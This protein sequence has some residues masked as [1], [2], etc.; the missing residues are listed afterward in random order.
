MIK[1]ALV[2]LLCLGVLIMTLLTCTAMPPIPVRACLVGGESPQAGLGAYGYLVFT[3]KA[4][5]DDSV[6]YMNICETYSQSMPKI[7]MLAG[8]ESSSLMVTFWMIRSA[9]ESEET[10]D[11]CGWLIEN[12]DYALAME[13]AS[14]IRKLDS[15]GPLLV[16]WGQPYGPTLAG[17][18][19]LV[20]DLSNFQDAD[21]KRGFNIWKDRITRNP[22]VWKKGFNLVLIREA[23]HNLIQIYGEQIVAIVK[24]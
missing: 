3:H 24:G 5:Q 12:Y 23:F 22:K 13:I 20:L 6:R 11:S 8:K 17:K 18:E 10:L 7:E 19:A 4:G 1:I 16:A 15:E 14:T 21:L 9:P 2:R